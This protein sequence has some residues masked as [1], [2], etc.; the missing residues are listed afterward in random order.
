MVNTFIG[1]Y[2]LTRLLNCVYA[3]AATLLGGYISAGSFPPRL[4]IAAGVVASLTAAGN[5]MNDYFDLEIDR[6][7]KPKRAIP[8]G[9]ISLISAAWW[10]VILSV[11]GLVLSLFLDLVMAMIAAG[12]LVLLVAYSWRLKHTFLLGN[13]AVGFMSA[14]TVVYGGMAVGNVQST[15]VLAFVI[16]LF[17]FCREILKTIED[18]EGDRLLGART[19]AVVLGKVSALRLFFGLALL[20]IALSLL[21]W[22]LNTVSII[23]PIL[24]I[25]GVNLV[26]LVVA[27]ILLKRP[28]QK[29]IRMSVLVT[30]ATWVFWFVAMFV[31]VVF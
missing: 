26:L 10:A 13:V 18:Y 15:I 14:M 25:P 3:S 11:I 2:R 20:V 22:L 24:V 21:P 1:A 16:L 6:I 28:T 4:W 9:Q 8:S 27:I 23:Y 29:A 12:I 17:I 5:V 19:V 31:G 30:K 7:N